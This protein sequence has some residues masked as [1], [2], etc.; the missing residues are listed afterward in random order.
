MMM[1]LTGMTIISSVIHSQ[2][3][4]D[5]RDFSSIGEA[6]FIKIADQVDIGS[7]VQKDYSAAQLPDLYWEWDPEPRWLSGVG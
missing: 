6:S 3:T 5:H 2:S 4:F 7:P 1:L